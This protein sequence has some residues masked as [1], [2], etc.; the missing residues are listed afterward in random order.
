M[1]AGVVETKKTSNF[2]IK[3]C[4]VRLRLGIKS[5]QV[6]FILRSVCANFALKDCE[7]RLRLGIKSKQVVL[8]SPLGLR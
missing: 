5:K 6:C 1:D 2:A 4:E 8:Y 7:V 3:N